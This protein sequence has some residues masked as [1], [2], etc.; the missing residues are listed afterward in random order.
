MQ[1]TIF[2]RYVSILFSSAMHSISYAR[3]CCIPVHVTT[4]GQC[5]SL[6]KQNNLNSNDYQPPFHKSEIKQ[7]STGVHFVSLIVLGLLYLMAHD[8][9]FNCFCL[10]ATSFVLAM[11]IP[12]TGMIKPDDAPEYAKNSMSYMPD[13]QFAGMEGST[14][15][16]KE[17]KKAKVKTTGNPKKKNKS[18]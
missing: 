17:T 5:V 8:Q 4:K 2:W 18:S 13:R 11:F 15:G 9:T 12:P 3:K 1:K 7:I 16:E 6:M 14:F 10:A